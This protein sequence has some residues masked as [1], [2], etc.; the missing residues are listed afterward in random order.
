MYQLHVV[1]HPVVQHK[2][3]QLRRKETNHM[4]FRRLTKEL[5]SF[6]LYEVMSDYPLKDVNIET[7]VSPMKSQLLAREISFVLILRA[8]LG[9]LEGPLDL[10]PESRVGHIGL[11][12]NEDTLDPVEYYV[13]LPENIADTDIIIVDPM[14][15]TGGSASK[16]VTMVKEA[17]G[18]TIKFVCMVAAPDGVERMMKDHP[19]VPIFS[20]ALDE[21]LNENG[22]IVPGL[23]D[24]GDRLFGTK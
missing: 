4:D 11:Y 15:A 20:A 8:G 2:L 13:K 6:M 17:G 21:K 9:M 5:T 19:D 24:A 22:Y 10:V 14:L 18:R 16:A 23:G 1:K 12:R 3:T 7:P